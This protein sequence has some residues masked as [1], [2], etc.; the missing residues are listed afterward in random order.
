MSFTLRLLTDLCS[1]EPGSVQPASVEIINRGE[2]LDTF[3]ITCEGLDPSWL[4]IPVPSFSVEAGDKRTER[5]LVQPPRE[6]DVAAGSYPFEIK[7]RSLN[8]AETHVVQAVAEVKA[9]HNISVAIEP[10]KGFVTPFKKTENFQITLINLGNAEQTVQFF[11]TDSD[12]K[13]V[14]HFEQ[15]RMTLSPGVQRTLNMSVTAGARSMFSGSRLM[16]L[17]VTARDVSSPASMGAVQA[18]LEQR[19]LAS[20]S[21]LI[22]IILGLLLLVAWVLAW[23]KKPELNDLVV[24]SRHVVTGGKLRVDWRMSNAERFE[25]VM[26]GE[27]VKKSLESKGHVELDMVTSGEHTLEGWAISGDHKSASR[28]IKID[29]TDPPVVP[30]PEILSFRISPTTVDLNGMLKVTYEVR[31]AVSAQLFPA[32]VTL[33]VS[34]NSLTLTASKEGEIDYKLV[35]TGKDGLSDAQTVHVSVKKVSAAKII[36]F[37]ANN[38]T[39][40]P[41]NPNVAISWQVLGAATVDLFDGVTHSTVEGQG[42]KDFIITKDTDFKITATDVDGTAVSKTIKVKIKATE[43]DQPPPTP[44][45]GNPPANDAHPGTDNPPH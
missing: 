7:V 37:A 24:D 11:A 35:V 33:P 22:G 41:D 2:S 30:K 31:N 9:Y 45:G 38:T 29:V 27:E 19:A 16:G 10:R 8:D 21:A 1:V 4:A 13:C 43:P 42:T 18:Q 26:D 23:P 3:E 39:V 36:A 44:D 32:G 34:G 14:F 6:S 40:T 17:Q 20:P 15:E 28:V 5:V 12:D 25:L